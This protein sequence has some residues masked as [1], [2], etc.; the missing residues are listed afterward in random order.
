MIL[1][2]SFHTLRGRLVIGDNPALLSSLDGTQWERRVFVSNGYTE[3]LYKSISPLS[4]EHMWTYIQVK[5]ALC[6]PI[7]GAAWIIVAGCGLYNS[8]PI[9]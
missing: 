9:L 7:P 4:T 5:S 6:S 2:P 8:L 3:M 1:K